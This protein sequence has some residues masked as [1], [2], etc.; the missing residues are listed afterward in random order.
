MIL[1]ERN[2]FADATAIST[3]ATGLALEGDVIDLGTDGVNDVEDM[4][5][6]VTVDTA[7]TSAGSA[8]VEFQLASD[9]QAAI[10]VDGSATVHAKSAAIA[11]ATLVAGYQ[12]FVVALPKGQ[13]ERYLGILQNVGTAALT[14][15]KI[16]A[17]L[18]KAPVTWKSFDAPFQL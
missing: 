3:A 15:G 12:A 14:A 10:A 6:V 17:F 1:D 2:E 7:V 18:T 5:L 16:N 11:K 8:T 9:A 13:Y 4:Y